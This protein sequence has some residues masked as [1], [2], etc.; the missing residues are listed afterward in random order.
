MK[1]VFLFACSIAALALTSCETESMDSNYDNGNEV[2][3]K[4][5]L[6]GSSV[7]LSSNTAGVLG[8]YD[9]ST[10]NWKSLSVPYADADG[11]SYDV[12]R[13]AVYHVNRTDNK[14]VALA[15]ISSTMDGDVLMPSAMGPSNFTQGRESTMYNNKVVVV[16]DVSPGRLVSYNVNEDNISDYRSIQTN[17]ELWG[18]QMVGKDLWAIEDAT[19]NIAYYQDF[20]KAK[21]G[22]LDVT[23]KVAVEGLVRTHG[24]NYD[25]TTDMMVLTDIGSAAVADDGGLIV[26]P[27]FSMVYKNAAQ[28]TGMISMS[29]QIRVYGDMTQLGNPVDVVISSSKGKIFVAERAQQKFLIFDIPTSDCNCAPEFSMDFAGASAVATDF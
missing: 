4:K 3:Q 18:I 2:S 12:N 15:N 6:N 21:S 1:K 24:L 9:L 27:N 17:I 22:D 10:G 25:A 20:F 28:G 7:Y 16:D 8:V 11:V 5:A 23:S 14:L 29:D 19:S 13:D 26:I